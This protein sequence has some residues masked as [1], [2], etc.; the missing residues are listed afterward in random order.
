METFTQIFSFMMHID[1]QLQVLIQQYGLY[2]YA[3]L[4][5]V[6]FGE[7]GFVVLPFLPGDSLLFIAGAFSADGLMNPWLLTVLLI[8]AA[9]LGNTVNYS[10]GRFIGKKAF[11]TDSRWISRDA[12]IKTHEFYERHGGKAI[13][14]ARFLPIVRTFAPFVAGV[15]EMNRVRF[16]Q[17]NI[18]GAVLWVTI[19]VWGG[20]WFGSVPIIRDHLSTIAIIGFLAALIPAALGF[21]WRLLQR[22]KK[23]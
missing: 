9:V 5:V 1:S 3:I 17:F 8:V 20:Y 15:S 23:M 19:F 22:K 12:L 4:F 16:Q 7:T 6:V 10:I 2:I 21:M 13:I 14:L 18:I 11:E